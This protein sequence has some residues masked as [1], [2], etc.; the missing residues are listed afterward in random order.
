MITWVELSGNVRENP[1]D[2][3]AS[4]LVAA[5]EQGDAFS[6]EELYAMSVLLQIGGHKTTTK[7]IGNGL[8]ALLQNPEEMQKPKDNPSLMKTAVEDASIM[9]RKYLHREGRS[10]VQSDIGSVPI[11]VLGDPCE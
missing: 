8:L 1:R 5:E 2:D 6:E 9:W 10:L 7:L 4:A 11:D 3:L